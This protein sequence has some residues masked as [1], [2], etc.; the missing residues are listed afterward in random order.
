MSLKDISYYSFKAHSLS[1]GLVIYIA[2]VKVT[3]TRQSQLFAPSTLCYNRKC[4]PK[5]DRNNNVASVPVA[6]L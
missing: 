2:N 3:L 1:E 5:S 6:L 4:Q